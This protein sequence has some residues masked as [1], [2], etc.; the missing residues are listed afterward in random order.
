MA[1]GYLLERL[2]PKGIKVVS[3]RAADG[4]VGKSLRRV[5]KGYSDE[6]LTTETLRG[7]LEKTEAMVDKL[8]AEDRE[9]ARRRA[10]ERP[11]LW[12]QNRERALLRAKRRG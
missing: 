6:E 10:K 4:L 11:S 1:R 8:Y 9:R 12:M 2:E 3:V 7:L 5:L